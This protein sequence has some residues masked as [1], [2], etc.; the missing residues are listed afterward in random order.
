MCLGGDFTAN[1]FGVEQAKD[2][3]STQ[4]KELGISKTQ[5]FK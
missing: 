4:I 3:F 1:V 5:K 2:V